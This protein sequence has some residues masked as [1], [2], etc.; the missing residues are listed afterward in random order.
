MYLVITSA[1]LESFYPASGECNIPDVV[2][3]FSRSIL[4]DSVQVRKIIVLYDS[5]SIY[6]A[7]FMEYFQ[8]KQGFEW[9]VVAF[10]KKEKLEFYL[11][12]NN[13]E[14]FLVGGEEG[15][16]TFPVEKVRYCYQ[17]TE[18]HETG[19]ENDKV[20]RYQS[21]ERIMEQVLSDYMRKQ[22]EISAKINPN[23]MNITTVYSS[24]PGG[25]DVSI[26][27]SIGFQLA[28]QRKALFVPLEIYCLSQLEFID[29][30]RHGLSEFIYYLKDN[31]NTLRRWKELLNYSNNLAYLSG[32]NHGFDVL[33]LNREDIQRWI[34]L[35]RTNTDYQNVVFYL[36]FYQEAGMEL[37]KLSDRVVVIRGQSPYEEAVYRDLERQLDCIGIHLQEPKFVSVNR[38]MTLG[39]VKTYHD[40]QEMIDSPIWQLAKDAL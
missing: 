27:W 24:V 40:L 29:Q 26:A 25:Q 35:L 32:A 14:V 21:V 22:D 23:R 36:G 15:M 18:D 3:Q 28:R 19:P 13:I 33:S 10:T 7:R 1:F 8:N 20:Y 16:E 6:A 5:D 11:E 39:E 37:L 9:E 38:T 4:E 17:L 34:E 2:R 31:S 12:G 30:N